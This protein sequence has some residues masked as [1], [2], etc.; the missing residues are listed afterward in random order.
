MILISKH[1]LELTAKPGATRVKPRADLTNTHQS[2]ASTETA[3]NVP[4][5][6]RRRTPI[7]TNPKLSWQ[8]DQT[9]DFN[10]IS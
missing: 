8:K 7:K 1:Y 9:D 5:H 10:L 6:Q 4:E 3:G 2:V